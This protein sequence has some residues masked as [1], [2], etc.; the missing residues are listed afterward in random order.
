MQNLLHHHKQ[1]HSTT[2]L[3]LN[4][5]KLKRKAADLL[6]KNL[7]GEREFEEC[8][9]EEHAE[10]LIQL[11]KTQQRAAEEAEHGIREEI[12]EDLSA[13]A[14]QLNSK[15]SR[16]DTT[17]QQILQEDA[18]Y[19]GQEIIDDVSGTGIDSNTLT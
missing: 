7:D 14:P 3:E 11:R 15:Y 1:S 4:Q 16:R 10:E 12:K 6:L 8:K 5:A 17:A 9:Y 13:I 19:R 2:D 18:P